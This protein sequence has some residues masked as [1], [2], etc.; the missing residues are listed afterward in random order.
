MTENKPK[1]FKKVLRISSIVILSITFISIIAHFVWLNTGSN[2]WKLVKEEDG[3][4]IWSMK[5]PGN[6]LLKCR[7]NFRVQCT[8]AGLVKIIE[9][10]KSWSDIGMDSSKITVLDPITAPGYYSAFVGFKQDMPFP[11]ADREIFTFMQRFQNSQSKKVE[12][13]VMAAPNK[14]PPSEGYIRIE[15]MHN[16][17]SF[18]PLANGEIEVDFKNEFDLGGSVPYVLKNIGAAPMLYQMMADLKRIMKMEKYKNAK[19]AYIKEFDE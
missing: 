13:N 3:I 18:T 6:C 1:R 17:Y 10:T 16:N 4:K 5:T 9:D 12:V 7:A 14:I 15:H 2:Q 11:F 8:M 19:V